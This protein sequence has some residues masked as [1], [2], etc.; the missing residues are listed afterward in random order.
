M[1][2][3]ASRSDASARSST[4]SIG[5]TPRSAASSATVR[6][7]S[8]GSGGNQETTVRVPA[9]PANTA[10]VRGRSKL[11]L[12]RATELRVA[13]EPRPWRRG[14][15]DRDRREDRHAL[16]R[17][18]LGH[19][20]SK[21]SGRQ[22]TCGMHRQALLDEQLR[23][24]LEQLPVGAGPHHAGE[25]RGPRDGPSRWPGE[26]GELVEEQA[27]ADGGLDDAAARPR[28]ARR[29][30]PRS[31]RTRRPGS[32]PA[33]R[34]SRRGWATSRWRS[35]SRRRRSPRRTMRPHRARSRR[36]WPAARSP[37]RP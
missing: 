32:A 28:R 19:W 6:S 8:D 33:C 35:R 20:N 30:A 22:L 12:K 9:R 21:L 27:A 26:L 10:P 3:R 29:R 1:R 25:Q 31:R 23:D 15:R 14:R 37:P 34:R 18:R 17:E 7:S 4:R 11:S 5:S 13:V 36:P 2:K 16:E 24:S